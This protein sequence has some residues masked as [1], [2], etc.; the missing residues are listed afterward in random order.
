MKRRI[1]S[2][3]IPAALVVSA[4]GLVG[5]ADTGGAVPKEDWSTLTVAAVTEPAS[6]DPAQAAEANFAQFYQ[7]VF[8]TLVRR[9]PDGELAPMLAT[10]WELSADGLVATMDLRDDVTFSDGTPFDA[11]VAEL[12]LE[13]FRDA[14]GPFSANLANLTDV[15]VVDDDTIELRL[16][17]AD[18]DLF[19]Y[20]GNSAGYMASP[21][22]FDGATV[23]TMPIGSGPYVLDRDETVT[24]SAYTYVRRDDYWDAGAEWDFFETLV[25]R[26]MP[27]PA[28]RMN[29]LKSGEVDTGIIEPKSIP[30][31]Q[32]AGLEVETFQVNW[33]GLSLFD[34]DGAMV[35]AL[36]DVR[37][38]QAM[39]YAIQVDEILEAV[40]LGYGTATDQTV[41]T[42]SEAFEPAFDTAYEYDPDR[43][44]ELLAE[45]GYADGFDL[46]MPG[47]ATMD[48]AMRAAVAQDLG[49]VGIRV[50]YQEI[51]SAEFI[52]A[53]RQGKYA[54]SWMSFAQ[55]PTAW[56]TV[57]RFL[58]P[59]SAWN[60]FGT[61][62]DRI[63][64]AISS[65]LEALDDPDAYAAALQEINRITVEEAWNVVFYRVEQ[66]IA[67]RVGLTVEGQ[68]GQAAP[69]I[70][71]YSVDG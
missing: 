68:A 1:R 19:Q 26:P 36:A 45:A 61:Q 21:A 34:R 40:E 28:A 63:D 24:G 31:A 44:R 18:P 42:V 37:V 27:D 5:C 67:S 17:V 15:V 53:L 8:D 58:Q 64:A 60:V 29:A 50:R 4:V 6:F 43:A 55:P 66:G 10:D 57:S 71:N 49:Q 39:N 9:M 23:A 65:A 11:G 7:P 25:I 51:S 52:P 46:T 38:R 59:T 47:T 35:P 62:D 33:Y 30:E 56:G 22:Q 3:A 69:S 2:L 14:G 54:A 41:S 32:A 13:R 16:S 12:N 70:Y 48:P 20:L